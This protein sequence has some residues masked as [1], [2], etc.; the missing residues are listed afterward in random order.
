MKVSHNYYKNGYYEV[1]VCHRVI[2]FCNRVVLEDGSGKTPRSRVAKKLQ[3]VIARHYKIGSGSSVRIY[4]PWTDNPQEFI[5][6]VL[7]R[8]P[9]GNVRMERI[10]KSLGFLPDNLK[11]LVKTA[12]TNAED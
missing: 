4:K 8:H 6:W 12:S 11:F 5:D 3:N 1:D 10:D 9:E 2:T 7:E